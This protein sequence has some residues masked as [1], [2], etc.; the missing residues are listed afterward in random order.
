MVDERINVIA[1]MLDD[2]ETLAKIGCRVGLSGER[3]RQLVVAHHLRGEDG[4]RWPRLTAAQRDQMD[5]MLSK[6]FL[7]LRSIAAAV[8]C[9]VKT[10]WL[11]KHRHHVNTRSPRLQSPTRCPDCG[12]V[13][14]IAPCLICT[15]REFTSV[16]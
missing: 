16:A 4:Q 10:V 12:H 1:S 6:G 11:R 7:S 2:G 3:V 9:S 14:V 5:R 8:G 15:A 13:V